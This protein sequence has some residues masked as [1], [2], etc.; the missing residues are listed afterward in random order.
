LA[1]KYISQINLMK[2]ELAQGFMGGGVPSESAFKL[3]DQILNPLYGKGQLDAAIDQLAVNLN[4]RK[5]A[6]SQVQARTLGGYVDSGQMQQP[7]AQAQPVA[8]VRVVDR[9]GQIGTIPQ[10]QLQD[11]LAQGYKRVG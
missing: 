5:N 10:D 1:T 3:A 9:N 8:R 11:A 4:I 6:I 7:Q 2:D